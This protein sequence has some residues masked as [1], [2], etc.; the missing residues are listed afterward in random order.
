[1][2]GVEVVE[3]GGEIIAIIVRSDCN[4]EGVSFVTSRDYPLQLG[5]FCHKKN[6]EIKPHIHR[7]FERV[8]KKTLE[9]LHIEYGC[10]SVD[11]YSSDGKKIKTITLNTGDT[12]MFINGGHGIRIIEDS[13]II[14]IKQG[15]YYGV[16][17]D[18]EYI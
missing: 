8:I 9:V 1:M 13:K 6:S 4:P 16:E 12:I 18:K 11:L 7:E 14:E 2:N 10:V 5:I 3:Y 15:P 17:V